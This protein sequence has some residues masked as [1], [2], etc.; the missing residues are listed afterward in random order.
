MAKNLICQEKKCTFSIKNNKFFIKNFI[1]W[2]TCNP[3]NYPV[4]NV[5]SLFLLLTKELKQQ[6]VSGLLKVKRTNDKTETQNCLTPRP[7]P[8][9]SC[10]SA[11]N[12]MIKLFL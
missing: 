12:D 3:C 4:R 1:R 8:L 10:S 9:T 5:P 7:I 6:E 11:G 2:I